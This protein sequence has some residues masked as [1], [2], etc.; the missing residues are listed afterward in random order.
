MSKDS[1]KIATILQHRMNET[2]NIDVDV[3]IDVDLFSASISL[4]RVSRI[5]RVSNLS[6]DPLTTEKKL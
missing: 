5:L 6:I 3:D 2:I 4:F 1:D